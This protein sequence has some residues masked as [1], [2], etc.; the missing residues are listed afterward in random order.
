[1]SAQPYPPSAMKRGWEG[2]DMCLS[3][4]TCN[5]EPEYCQGPLMRSS[6]SSPSS[7]TL[8]QAW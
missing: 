3:R 2:M 5:Q 4:G 1:M 8:L 7:Q 6:L